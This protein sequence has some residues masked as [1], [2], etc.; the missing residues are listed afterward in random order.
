MAWNLSK[1]P[2]KQ[3]PPPVAT[4]C[5]VVPM[6]RTETGRVTSNMVVPGI[7]NGTV[8]NSV[9]STVYVTSS[10]E[11]VTAVMDMKAKMT[12]VQRKVCSIVLSDLKEMKLG[13]VYSVTASRMQPSLIAMG[14]KYGVLIGKIYRSDGSKSKQLTTISEESDGSVTTRSTD[15]DIWSLDPSHKQLLLDGD[16]ITHP[17]ELHAR[18]SELK[19]KN[20][21]LESE[22]EETFSKSQASM[23]VSEQKESELRAQ[24][25]TILEVSY[26]AIPLCFWVSLSHS[27]TL[28]IQQQQ[29]FCDSTKDELQTALKSIESLQSALEAKEESC[30]EMEDI[31]ESLREELGTIKSKLQGNEDNIENTQPH[32]AEAG[33]AIEI[34]EMRL[35]SKNQYC[36]TLQQ[37]IN[38]LKLAKKGGEDF[39]EAVI[40][41][42]SQIFDKEVE[43]LREKEQSLR[44]YVSLLEEDKAQLDKELEGYKQRFDNFDDEK[45]ELQTTINEQTET[46]KNLMDLLDTREKEHEE[47]IMRCDQKAS[48]LASK[49]EELEGRLK[50]ETEIAMQSEEKM[51]ATE[52]VNVHLKKVRAIDL[53]LFQ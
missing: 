42:A 24:M 45:K 19:N 36:E 13:D 51:I 14:T 3:W 7:L 30:A 11:I 48:I 34:L 12:S 25:T 9:I 2:P 39:D 27:Y 33:K 17:N 8:P 23:K 40:D 38:T 53:L 46:L 26:V 31:M 35:A 47:K 5:C 1:L 49:Y 16:R 15:L 22:L 18:L 4:P 41:D 32:V 37:E 44:N 43:E 21:Q 10:C 6:L 20:R 50:V 29:Q 28:E 52:S